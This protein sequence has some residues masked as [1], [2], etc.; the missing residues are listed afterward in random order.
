MGRCINILE[1]GKLKSCMAGYLIYRPLWE[2]DG[3][4]YV[5]ISLRVVQ[6]PFV[7]D[8]LQPDNLGSES[9]KG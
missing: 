9:A 5:V 2:L 6:P 1:H 3:G 8:T 7:E 4:M